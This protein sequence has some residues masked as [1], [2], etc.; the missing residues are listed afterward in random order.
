MNRIIAALAFGIASVSPLQAADQIRIGFLSTLSGPGAALGIDIRDGFNLGIKHAGGKLG[1]LR[2]DLVV[3]DDQQ[4]P[5]VARQA[6]ERFVKSQKADILTGVVFS[7]VLLPI[8]P[9]I[10]QSETVYISPNTGPKD[11]AGDKCSPYFYVTSWQNEDIPGA[12]GKYMGE[13]GSKNVHLIAPN[14]PGGRET[15]E[16]FKRLYKGGATEEI[17][18]KLGQLDYSADLAALRAAKPDAAYV[19]LP[20]GMGVNFIKQFVAAG[21]NSEVPLFLYGSSADEDTIKAVGDPMVG[22]FNTAQWSPDFDNPQNRNFVAEF[23]KEYGR[24]PTMH[25]SQGYDTALL[26]DAAVRDVK[27]K[28]EDKAALRK[29]LEAANFK[30]VRGNFRFN[31]NHYPIQSIYLRQVVKDA[32]G[33]ITNKTVSRVLAD[34][35][36]AY[37][38]S[39]N[40]R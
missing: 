16:G 23:Q 13:K 37:A 19:F 29:A 3:V 18:T 6:V 2:V 32:G 34:H 22:I 31:T 12:A 24:L 27:G 5:D 4:N 38:S 21:L 17:Y 7:S 15:V 39:C 35:A 1:G 9:A 8:L 28:L 33:R 36:D 11:Y 40:M 10:V 14:Y 26:I 25:A 20:G 30:S